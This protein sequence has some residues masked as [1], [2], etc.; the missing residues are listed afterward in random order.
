MLNTL[1][2]GLQK[3]RN[4]L[5]G[6]LN[7]L[8]KKNISANLLEDLETLLLQADLGIATC[9][10]IISEIT[11]KLN[12]QQLTDPDCV[13]KTLFTVLLEILKPCEKPIIIPNNTKP[14]VILFIGVNGAGKTTTIGKLANF[15]KNNNK[16]VVL[17]CGDTFRAAAIEQLSE[18]GAKIDVPV[19]KQAIGS[20]S[21]S[22]IFDA[23]TFAVNNNYDILIADT[24]GR[25]HTKKNLMDELKK[26]NNVLKKLD[27]KAPHE[28][29]LV[30]DA[31]IGQNSLNQAKN[32]H[33]AMNITGITITK[34]DGTAKAGV[35]FSIANIMHIPIR[36]IGVGEQV[37]DLKS[38]NAE[39]F[40]SA[41]CDQEDHH[42]NI[43]HTN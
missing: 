33:E 21:A 1:K 19:I 12:R 43:S 9:D 27:P 35:I 30:L 22:V 25:L 38:F 31:S 26:V 11:K 42:T 37:S 34:L 6:G 36:Y 39:Q 3:T 10:K 24:A 18:W 7:N 40:I 32:F 17:A 16:K 14:F 15:Y 29:M 13:Y 8:F 2:K 28:V 4:Y 41:L 5:L 23:Y 20:D